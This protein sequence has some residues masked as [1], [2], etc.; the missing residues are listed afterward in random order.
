MIDTVNVVLFSTKSHI[1]IA[2]S[3]L[4]D[5]LQIHESSE[6]LIV[7]MEIVLGE[8]LANVIKHTYKNDE[9]K[10][11]IVSYTLK[12]EVFHVLVRDFGP[13]VD[14]ARLKPTPPDLE[15]PREGGYG[16]YIISRVTDEFRVRPLRN[17]NLT[18]VKKKLR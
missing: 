7:D 10:R 12:D 6:S 1:K 13:P 17:G 2:R 16:L 14:P 4:R 18:V 9:T 11:I 8:I 3:V 15:N 5:F